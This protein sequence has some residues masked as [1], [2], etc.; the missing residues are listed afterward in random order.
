M[1]PN[2]IPANA[3]TGVKKAHILEPI[4][5]AYTALTATDAGADFII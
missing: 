4:T 5:V 2:I 3:P 1:F